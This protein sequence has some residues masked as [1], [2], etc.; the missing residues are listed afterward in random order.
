M[1][2]DGSKPPFHC[3]NIPTCSQTS[4]ILSSS[5]EWKNS[6]SGI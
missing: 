1:I 3:W 6:K 5:E 2:K 4:L